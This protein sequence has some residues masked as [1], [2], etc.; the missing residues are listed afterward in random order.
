[1]FRTLIVLCGRFRANSFPTKGTVL[2]QRF[3]LTRGKRLLASLAVIAAGATGGALAGV[4]PAQAESA[5][6]CGHPRVC[7]YLTQANWNARNYTAAYR[8]IT[9]G[10]QTLG[11]TS[12]GA[13][14]VFNTRDTDSVLLHF[15][16]GHTHCM[17]PSEGV[18][19]AD[20]RGKVDK[21]RIMNSRDCTS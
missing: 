14:A 3:S 18:I 1:M 8:D 5:Y 7:F 15:T 16:D 2:S 11:S 9:S 10:Y 12:R 20:Q 17:E 4:T 21:V 19:A 13:Y 6:G